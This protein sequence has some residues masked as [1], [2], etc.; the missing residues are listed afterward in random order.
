[1]N[2]CPHC[3]ARLR[4][5]WW[6]TQLPQS[7]WT[8]EQILRTQAKRDALIAYKRYREGSA[9]KPEPGAK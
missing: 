4:D 2:T 8:Q 6:E 7:K 1:M 3:N 5:F 9:R